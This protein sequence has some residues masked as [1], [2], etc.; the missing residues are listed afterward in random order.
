MATQL[1]GPTEWS[2]SR[3]DDGN[4]EYKITHLIKCD[5]TDGPYN[6]LQTIGLPQ[7]GDPWNFDGDSDPWATCKQNATV[8]PKKTEEPNL[9]F[10]ITQTF[11]TKADEKRCKDQQIEEPL[12]EPQKV[13]GAGNTYQEEGTYDR[14]GEPIASSSHELFKGPQN[15]WDANRPSVKI[16]QNVADLELALCTSMQDTLNDSTLWGVPARCIKLSKFSWERKFYGACYVYYTRVFEFDIRFEGFDR[17]LLDEGTKALNGRWNANGDWELV[18]IN[19]SLPN[20]DNPAHFQR[21]KDRNGENCT[22]V[23][24]GLGN[25]ATDDPGNTPGIIHVEKYGESNFLTLGIPTSF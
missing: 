8:T 17:D 22:V 11:S 7:P 13:S 5:P 1:L 18:P 3:D 25:P 14:N 4:R 24:N 15:E 21:F 9:F 12:L 6:A 23:L 10:T 19:G 16:E 20:P 2:M